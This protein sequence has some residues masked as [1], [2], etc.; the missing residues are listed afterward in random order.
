M[1]QIVTWDRL[2]L[3]VYIGITETTIKEKETKNEKTI[4][5]TCGID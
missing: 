3:S 5:K 2:Q 4:S 1:L